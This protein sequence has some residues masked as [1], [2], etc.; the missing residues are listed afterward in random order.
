MDAEVKKQVLRK[1]TYG[2][3]VLTAAH[4]G[5]VAAG[6]VNWLSQCSFTPPLVMVSVKADSHL[7]ALIDRSGGFAVN[8]LSAAQKDVAQ[9]F[10]RPTEVKDGR[11][12]GYAYEP[13]PLTGAPLLVDLPAWFECRVTDSVKRGDHTVFVGEVVEV[14]L[15]DAA[16]RPLEM[17]DTGWFYGG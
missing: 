12:N 3:Y 8:V 6:T 15:R 4:G 9:A 11:L 16:A 7:H 10:F 1:L 2:L 13:G 5:E 14:G 17:W